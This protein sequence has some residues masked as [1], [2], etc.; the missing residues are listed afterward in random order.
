MTGISPETRV[1]VRVTKEGIR[2]EI[3]NHHYAPSLEQ[4][5]SIANDIEADPARFGL[6]TLPVHTTEIVTSLR[7]AA[8]IYQAYCLGVFKPGATNGD[9]S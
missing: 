3:G 8:D 1:R 2:L 5:R 9:P 4:A 6:E 7:K